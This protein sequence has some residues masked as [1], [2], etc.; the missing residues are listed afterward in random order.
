[1]A[2]WLFLFDSSLQARRDLVENN[3]MVRPGPSAAT[4]TDFVPLMILTASELGQD[5][6][7]VHCLGYTRVG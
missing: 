6:C 7:P 5:F 2:I 4:K 3:A 1:M